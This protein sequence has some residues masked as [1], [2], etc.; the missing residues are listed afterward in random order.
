MPYKEIRADFE[1]LRKLFIFPE[2]E[3]RF[4]EFGQ[5]ILNMLHSYFREKGGI[6]SSVSLKSLEEMFSEISI[7]RGP[8]LLKDI[9]SEIEEKIISNSVKV[10]S[11]YYIGH[12]TSAIPYYSIFV[13]MIIAALNQNQVK[14]ETAKAST[15]VER[16]LICWIHRLI[17]NFN[18]EYYNSSIQN[19]NVS[20]GS[21]T[22]DGTLA[23]LT[24]LLIARNK[25][26][27]ADGSFRGISE[28]GIAEAYKY[29][30]VERSVVF[31]SRRGHYSIDKING[32]LGVGTRNIIK[33]P[34]DKYNKADVNLLKHEISKIEEHNKAGGA[35]IKI[36]AIVAVAG[37]TETGNIDDLYEIRKCAESCGAHYHVDAA[38][39]GPVL[40]VDQYRTLFR[41]IE[42][43]DSVTFDSHKLLYLPLSM[44]MVLFRNE[45]DPDFI[46]HN[47][48]YILRKDSYDLG[49]FTVEGSRPFSALRP[50]VAMKVFGSEGFR[51]LFENAFKLTK[52][53]QKSIINSSC[54]E[55]LNIPELFI[56]NYRFIP[57]Q[58]SDFI[59]ETASSDSRGY[60]AEKIIEINTALNDINKDLHRHLRHEDNSFV[61]RT[62]LESTQYHGQM[63]VSLRA[64]TINPL[65]DDN[66]LSEILLEQQKLGEMIFR[67]YSVRIDSIIKK[68]R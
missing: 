43:A 6:H 9:F 63:I 1:H 51:L 40:F 21:V 58:I 48:T 17:Y 23:N 67:D 29:Y 20:L 2:S 8:H 64:V 44:G 18:D 50:W 13:E 36:I 56:I 22:L 30:N 19:R 60:D 34:V 46:K 45:K 16:E 35:R 28:E 53:F 7:P 15:F 42:L 26:F 33:I 57:E 55:L 54:F 3:D 39:G 38:W 31:V 65:T 61:S 59:M 12:M 68:P 14:I 25:A 47:S 5:M 41:G 10:S 37:S 4:I 24:A 62:V 32:I 49:R 11:P 27:P 66:I 52:F